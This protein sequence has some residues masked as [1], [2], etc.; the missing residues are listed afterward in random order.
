MLESGYDT[1]G[2]SEG[3]LEK[4]KKQWQLSMISWSCQ[5]IEK[6]IQMVII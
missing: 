4:I 3:L 6:K 2:Y 5:I 1:A